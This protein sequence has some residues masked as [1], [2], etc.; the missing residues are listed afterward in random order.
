MFNGLRKPKFY[1]KCK[2]DLKLTKVRLETIKKKRNAMQKFLK[3]DVVDLLRSG[4]DANAYRKAEALLIE[5]NRTA[6]YEFVDQFCDCIQM[7]LDVMLKER[8]C[9]EECREAVSSLIYAAARLADLPELRDLRT[10]FTEK[11]GSSLEPF[12]NKEFAQKLRADPP[13]KEMKLQLMHDIAEEFSLHWNPK[14][15]EQNL[16][17]PPPKQD[18][19]VHN[20]SNE[21]DD[22]GCTLDKLDDFRNKEYSMPKRNRRPLNSSR[23]NNDADTKIKY[24]LYSSSEEDVNGVSES[25]STDL[26]VS[27]T[28]SSSDGSASEDDSKKK[29]RSYRSIPAPYSRPR[30]PK[31]AT[32]RALSQKTRG[33]AQDRSSKQDDTFLDSMPNPRS[34]RRVPSK[35]PSGLENMN[36]VEDNDDGRVNARVMAREIK[37]R[38]SDEDDKMIDDLLMHYSNKKSP[39]ESPSNWNANSK[40]P[41]KEAKTKSRRTKS[42]ENL[43]SSEPSRVASFPVGSTTSDHGTKRG[44]T[45]AQSLQPDKLSSHVHPKLPDYDDLAAQLAA[46]R[47]R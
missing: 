37:R 24:K 11:Y 10:L 20:L 16:F 42:A 7:N 46:L 18:G 1:T 5:Q 45:R 8:D 38:S 36:I 21:S 33:V 40:N 43:G 39:S 6:C 34:V 17:K 3:G 19:T 9:P 26:D 31:E 2:S 29:P 35:L 41:S 13:T 4:L 25:F 12:L 32:D 22:N 47:G 23:H 28:S 15:L 14:A 27:G 44:H 30:V